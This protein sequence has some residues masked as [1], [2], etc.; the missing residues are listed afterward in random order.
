MNKFDKEKAY[1]RLMEISMEIGKIPSPF[2]QS[3]EHLRQ[4][5]NFMQSLYDEGYTQGL[6]DGKQEKEVR[7]SKSN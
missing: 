5:P 4:I 7:I 2:K 3:I 6:K 1:N